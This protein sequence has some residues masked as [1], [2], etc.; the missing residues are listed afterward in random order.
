MAHYISSFPQDQLTILIHLFSLVE[1][2]LKCFIF[3]TWKLA[4][5]FISTVGGR[6]WNFSLMKTVLEKEKY[7]C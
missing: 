4:S 6:E 7:H 2:H 3:E 5:V 1:Q